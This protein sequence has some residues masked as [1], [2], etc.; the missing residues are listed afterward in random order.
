M[1]GLSG[2]VTDRLELGVI[3]LSGG[4]G[5]VTAGACSR[6]VEVGVTAGC[7]IDIPDKQ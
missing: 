6:R 3:R 4:V 1:L 2:G 5:R 7:V